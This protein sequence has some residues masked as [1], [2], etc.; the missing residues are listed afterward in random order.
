LGAHVHAH[1][2]DSVPPREA[3]ADTYQK[4]SVEGPTREDVPGEVISSAHTCTLDGSEPQNPHVCTHMC[5]EVC[6]GEEEDST[7]VDGAEHPSPEEVWKWAVSLWE[8]K[9][10][11]DPTTTA[12]NLIRHCNDAEEIDPHTWHRRLREHDVVRDI[13]TTI[14]SM[15]LADIVATPHEWAIMALEDMERTGFFELPRDLT[16]ICEEIETTYDLYAEH[17]AE[18]ACDELGLPYV[19]DE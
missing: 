8:G 16:E 3:K 1:V 5:K 2:G 17:E 15:N 13:P 9:T 19:R 10:H 4:F 12:A 7:E 18:E 14:R 6:T 11:Q